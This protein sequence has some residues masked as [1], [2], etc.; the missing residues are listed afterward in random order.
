MI[1][2]KTFAGLIALLLPSLATAQNVDLAITDVSVVDVERGTIES[3]RTVVV[4]EGTISLILAPEEPRP[5]A[6]ETIDGAGKFLI[7]GLIDMHV[8]LNRDSL[9]LFLRFGVTTVRDMGT[10]FAPLEADSGG[11]LAMR[12][13]IASG[14][15][16]GPELVLALR[17]LDGDI[18]RNPD[19]AMHYASIATPEEGRLLVNQV[20]S[21][22][23]DFVKVYTDLKPDVFAAIADEAK[24]RNLY[25]AGH[26]PGEVGHI[27]AAEAGLRTAEHL[28]GIFIDISADEDRWRDEFAAEAAKLDPSATYLF[29][30]SKLIEMAA[31][32]DTAK[33]TALFETLRRHDVGIVPTLVVLDDPRWLYPSAMPDPALTDELSFIYKSIVTPRGDPRGP[34]DSIADGMAAHKLRMELVGRMHAAG[35]T[36]LAG[37]D[38]SNPFVVPGVSMHTELANLVRAGMTPAEAIHAA[39]LA[40]A[41]YI[42]A[43]DRIGS[44]TVGK[45]ADLVLLEA[46]PLD[47]IT[48]TRQIAEVIVNGNR[49]AKEAKERRAE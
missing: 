25:I 28:R 41:R 30:N 11:Q 15:L 13:E 2:T 45:E 23:A 3:G 39:T 21:A 31:T 49:L 14:E 24:R 46:N 26:V 12:H 36:V 29:T 27:A 35:V 42:D 17:I 22:G 43:A 4:N 44:V 9:P 33:E 7:P 18:P 6:S 5:E 16:E 47:D 20:A 1:F 40:N 19:W 32:R 10:H 38:A 34:F 8:H 48:A 37:T